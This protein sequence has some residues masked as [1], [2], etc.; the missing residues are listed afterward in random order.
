LRKINRCAPGLTCP[1]PTTTFIKDVLQLWG[2]PSS[3]AA[4][5]TWRAHIQQQAH[6]KPTL[7]G[8]SPAWD[9]ELTKW[10]PLS[11]LQLFLGLKQLARQASP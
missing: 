4:S 5:Q 1:T 9:F 10:N 6:I 8:K 3:W 11:S 7:A 2:L